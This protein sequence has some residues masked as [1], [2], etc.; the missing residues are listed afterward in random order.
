MTVHGAREYIKQGQFAPGSM[1]PKVQACV[2]FVE[3]HPGGRALIAS[4]E[5]ATETLRGEGGT[6][7]T[8]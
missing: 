2:E 8:A 3:A 6:L 1:L 7:I 5:H 4:L